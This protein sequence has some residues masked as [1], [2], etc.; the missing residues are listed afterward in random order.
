MLI[1]TFRNIEASMTN[2]DDQ[3][4]DISDLYGI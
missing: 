1:N 4:D 2:T 3:T